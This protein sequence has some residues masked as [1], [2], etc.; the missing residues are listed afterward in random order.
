MGKTTS[1]IGIPQYDAKIKTDEGLE[2]GLNSVLAWIKVHPEFNISRIEIDA[3]EGNCDIFFKFTF[4]NFDDEQHKPRYRIVN[5]KPKRAKI[6]KISLEMEGRVCADY[7]KR[8]IP[9]YK[10]LEKYGITPGTLYGHKSAGYK[11]GILPR[12]QILLSHRKL[13]G[14]NY[15]QIRRSG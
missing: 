8:E 2:S 4:S 15:V 10:L 5:E 9:V 11:D 7:V 6:P 1:S 12:H 3:E 13:L 14:G